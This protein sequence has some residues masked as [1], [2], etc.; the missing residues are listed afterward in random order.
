M[1]YKT[2]LTVVDTSNTDTELTSTLE[3]AR[4]AGSHLA[5]L[6]VAIT[7]PPPVV[8]YG[9]VVL[10]GSWQA[11]IQKGTEAL[12]ERAGAIEKLMQEES[13]P[14]DV[15]TAHC[16]VALIESVAAKRAMVCD[17]AYLGKAP[18][19]SLV[20]AQALSGILFK[21]PIAV[22]ID[23][24]NALSS[25]YP[26]RVFVAWNTNREAAASVHQAL[27]ILRQAEEV[28]IGIFDPVMTEHDDGEEPGADCAAWLSRQGCAVTVQQYPS[29]GR[30]V[31]ECIAQ[32]ATETGAGLVVM[33]A[34][35]HSRLRQ[36]IFGGTTRS[37]IEQSGIPVFLAH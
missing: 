4:E 27:P 33:G 37:M 22:I 30:P 35:G 1:S 36:M 18:A 19:E 9:A 34:Y 24:E 11:D 7:P 3:L 32:R 2:I 17:L 25:L 12:G 29:G 15:T 28:T 6:L 23:A 21:S 10:P 16:D 14:G 20:A 26:K 5:V 13:V 31:A 8:D